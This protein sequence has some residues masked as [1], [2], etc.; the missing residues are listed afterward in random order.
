MVVFYISK[1]VLHEFCRCIASIANERV[2]HTVRQEIR[3]RLRKEGYAK[4]MFGEELHEDRGIVS[5][6]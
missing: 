6:L 3:S 1:L 5:V 4:D 2:E